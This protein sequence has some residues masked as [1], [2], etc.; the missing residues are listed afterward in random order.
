M[1]TI[2][3]LGGMSWE[4]SATYYRL[5]NERVR[6]RRGG[7]HSAPLIMYSVDFAEIEAFQES[8]AW[9]AA[10]AL[11][12]DRARRVAA[13]GAEF[14]VL[15]TNTMHLIADEIAASV[16]IPLL[17]IADATATTL[18]GAG[19]RRIGLLGTSYTMEKDFYKRYLARRYGIDVLVPDTDDRHT[20]NRV[21]YDE[22]VVG[23]VKPESKRRYLEIIDRLAD[24]GATAVILGCTEID[25]LVSEN[26]TAIPLYDTTRI[27][28][29]TAADIALGL[30]LTP[31]PSGSPESADRSGAGGHLLPHEAAGDTAAR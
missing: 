22:L 29:E 26:D 20:V 12:S 28:A 21:I 2:G 18:G 15:C 5:I 10:A 25:L 31:A 27:H 8:G 24:A 14:L 16:E 19:H 9:D 30:G 17:H 23:V 4:S 6:R 13:A 1:R 11:L 7:F 3:L